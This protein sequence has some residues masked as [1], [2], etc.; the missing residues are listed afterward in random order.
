[1][2]YPHGGYRLEKVKCQAWGSPPGKSK[3]TCTHMGPSGN[4][5]RRGGP[6]GPLCSHARTPCAVLRTTQH[7]ARLGRACVLG[8]PRALSGGFATWVHGATGCLCPVAH[9]CGQGGRKCKQAPCVGMGPFG[10]PWCQ[11]GPQ[12]HSVLVPMCPQLGGSGHACPPMV[13]RTTLHALRHDSFSNR[14]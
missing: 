3:I 11:A 2:V 5:A 1:M 8:G 10:C 6:L 12:L 14:L 13:H 7:K 9:P 4:M